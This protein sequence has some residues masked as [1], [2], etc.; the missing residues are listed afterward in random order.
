MT[1]A[2]FDDSMTLNHKIV[3]AGNAAVGLWVRM[4]TY[5]CGQLT[6]GFV[7]SSVAEMLGTKKELG[8]IIA[9]N[10]AHAVD[11]GYQIHD[12]LSYQPSKEAVLADRE[13]N[14]ARVERHRKPSGKFGNGGSNGSSNALRTP[15]VTTAPSR[16]VPEE[17]TQARVRVMG[18][19]PI[20]GRWARICRVAIPGPVVHNVDSLIAEYATATDSPYELAAETCLTEFYDWVQTW[21]VSSAATPALFV[22]HWPTIQGRVGKRSSGKVQS[23]A[24]RLAKRAMAARGDS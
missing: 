16:P 11:G 1:W 14:R 13:A 24:A 20:E 6:D 8:R 15:L 23:A 18:E 19:E 21:D 5:S 10:L 22:K 2:R 7:P 9:G 4:I 12:F 17:N 3:V